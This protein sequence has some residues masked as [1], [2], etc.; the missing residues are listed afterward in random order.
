MRRHHIIGI[1]PSELGGIATPGQD[2]KGGNAGSGS[3]S[4]QEHPARHPGHGANLP[5]GR[6][7]WLR[8]CILIMNCETPSNFSQGV[9]DRFL[10]GGGP[11]L[12][13][14]FSARRVS[15]RIYPPHPHGHAPSPADLPVVQP[16][17]FEF[18]INLV[19]ARALWLEVPPTLLARADEVIE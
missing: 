14:G 5:S 9:N 17:K 10:D 18:V 12:D 6:V 19:T 15:A 7:R 4:S 13:D 3:G 8:G 1:P 11:F 2:S 16:T